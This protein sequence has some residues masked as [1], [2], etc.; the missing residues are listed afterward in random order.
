MKENEYN[1]NIGD[2]YFGKFTIPCK[3]VMVFKPDSPNI[4]KQVAMIRALLGHN[5]CIVAPNGAVLTT[6][7]YVERVVRNFE[8]KEIVVSVH[9]A[10]EGDRL[11]KAATSYHH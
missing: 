9:L 8:N 5:A 7:L 10:D 11:V 2:S 1:L 6:N 3:G 4:K